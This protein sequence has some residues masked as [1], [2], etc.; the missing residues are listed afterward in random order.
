[1]TEC[2]YDDFVS[3]LKNLLKLF[4]CDC[5]FIKYHRSACLRNIT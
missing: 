4:C 3:N 1:M 5:E 2:Y